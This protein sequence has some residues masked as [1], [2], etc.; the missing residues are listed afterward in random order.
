MNRHQRRK[1]SR[2]RKEAKAAKLFSRA[3]M[4]LREETQKRNLARK[5]PNRFERSGCL[6]NRGIYTGLG[7]YPAPG[8][9]TGAFKEK[10]LGERALREQRSRD[11]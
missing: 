7:L 2:V 8:Y 1:L 10:P 5:R 4:V 11:K 3:V 9:G 6:G